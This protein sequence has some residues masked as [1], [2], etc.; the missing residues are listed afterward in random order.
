MTD[1][2]TEYTPEEL[3]ALPQTETVF[4]RP[5]LEFD[6]HEWQQEGYFITDVCKTVRP[7]CHPGGIPIPSGSLLVKDAKGYRLVDEI[8]KQSV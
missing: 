6:S 1:T 4:D 7:D 5:A 2:S 8:T 3:A